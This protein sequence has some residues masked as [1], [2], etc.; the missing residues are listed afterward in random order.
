M[1]GGCGVRPR[2]GR[3]GATRQADGA[4]T[5]PSAAPPAIR[6]RIGLQP[7]S[8]PP[9]RLAALSEIRPRGVARPGGSHFGVSLTRPRIG[10]QNEDVSRAIAALLAVLLTTTI[11]APLTCVGWEGSAAERRECCKRAEH[12]GCPDQRAADSCC[13]AHEQSRQLTPALSSVAQA[14]PAVVAASPVPALDSAT[15][16]RTT[17]L[18]LDVVLATRLH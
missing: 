14:P 5:A 18:L 8:R 2:K 13:A 15:L 3:A 6:G 16:D 7:V 12:H 11:A 10:G 17:A 9:P 4:T 1:R